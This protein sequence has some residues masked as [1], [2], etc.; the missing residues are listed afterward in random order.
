MPPQDKLRKT[1]QRLALQS[2]GFYGFEPQADLFNSDF[3]FYIFFKQYLSKT[4]PAYVSL[5]TS[6]R[7]SNDLDHGIFSTVNDDTV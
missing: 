6:P 3:I 7:L 1:F 2:V 4:F 5:I